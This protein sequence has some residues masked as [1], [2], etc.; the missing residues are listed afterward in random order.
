MTT[1]HK[2]LQTDVTAQLFNR[3]TALERCERR[4]YELK[5]ILA[6]LPE[7]DVVRLS[8]NGRQMTTINDYFISVL[9]RISSTLYQEICD[10]G[11]PATAKDVVEQVKKDFST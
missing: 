1:E 6:E 11:F 4:I 7:G 8:I 9:G 3:V 5:N 2:E 10:M